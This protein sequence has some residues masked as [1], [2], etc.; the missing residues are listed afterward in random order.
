MNTNFYYNKYLKYK[1]KYLKYKKQFGGALGTEPCPKDVS[2][3]TQKMS[4]SDFLRKTACVYNQIEK[5][6]R[7]KL[8]V[9]DYNAL[10]EAN[11]GPEYKIT[12]TDLKSRN[13]PP[14]FFL[15]K[16][17]PLVELIKAGYLVF[18]LIEAGFTYKDMKDAGISLET[19]TKSGLDLSY[20]NPKI[21]KML[22]EE[23]ISLEKLI[24]SKL[25]SITLPTKKEEIL[26][27]LKQEGISLEKLIESKLDSSSLNSIKK[28]QSLKMLKEAGYTLKDFFDVYVKPL[29][30]L[31][32]KNETDLTKPNKNIE[33]ALEQIKMAGFSLED[34]IKLDKFTKVE[35]VKQFSKKELD[36][37]KDKEYTRE[38]ILAEIQDKS[39]NINSTKLK[40]INYSRINKIDINLI[41]NFPINILYNAGYTMEELLNGGFK[42]KQLIEIFREDFKKNPQL[43][44]ILKSF[45][46]LEKLLDER[47]EIEDLL[48]IGYSICELKE[49]NKLKLESLKDFIIKNNNLLINLSSCYTLRELLD[50]NFSDLELKILELCNFSIEE[51]LSNGYTLDKL[52]KKYGLDAITIDV[53]KNF[54]INDIFKNNDLVKKFENNL[55]FQLIIK[56]KII[57][58][59]QI[60]SDILACYLTVEK[61]FRLYKLTFDEILGFGFKIKDIKDLPESVIY[62]LKKGNNI[63]FFKKNNF[64]VKNLKT[65]GRY[66]AT[67]FREA[68]YTCKELK[69]EFHALELKDA[70]Y[71]ICEM[72]EAEYSPLQLYF[73]GFDHKNI[74]EVSGP[75]CQI[76]LIDNLLSKLKVNDGSEVDEGF[77]DSEIKLSYIQQIISN[78]S[79]IFMALYLLKNK[80][81]PLG[82]IFRALDDSDKIDK[83]KF[84][85]TPKDFVESDIEYK[86]YF[87]KLPKN[88]LIINNFPVKEFIRADGEYPSK[89]LQEKKKEI[90]IN[91]KELKIKNAIVDSNLSL[92]GLEIKYSMFNI[93]ETLKYYYEQPYMTPYHPWY[94]S[95]KKIDD[96]V[97]KKMI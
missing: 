67:E 30:D 3:D 34:I 45:F 8:A 44:T 43:L 48:N 64:T 21:L 7:D 20:H 95:L 2:A 49:K 86:E 42:P 4:V 47:I 76:Q 17:Y 15:G 37:F 28:E 92:Q 91:N 46:T 57:T 88:D 19:L 11:S 31:L 56:N 81:I 82:L 26:K 5:H 83:L 1:N 62:F 96:E 60:N 80:E 89:T 61:L 40:E 97:Y 13:F 16:G 72:L 53:L 24:E 27:M 18:R 71:S 69:S 66:T 87:K 84:I 78:V 39:G 77:S 54:F 68:G 14:K 94:K 79:D 70:D 35:L 12:I 59:K 93:K 65:I 58:E 73:L 23:G 50:A 74:I 33:K 9:F 32:I 25:D 29:K 85:F 52:I 22:K 36:K 6:I 63:D 38:E 41:N 75:N 10:Q 90:A 55:I 51:I